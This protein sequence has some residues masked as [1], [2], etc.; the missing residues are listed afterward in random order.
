MKLK[1]G[2]I[3]GGQSPEHEVSIVSARSIASALEKL[4]HHVSLLFIDKRGEWIHID[5]MEE[6]FE[7]EVITQ[8]LIPFLKE[9]D[10]AFPIV[11]GRLGE[12]GALQGFLKMFNIPFVGADVLSSAVCMDKIIS[13]RLLSNAHL[14]VAPYLTLSKVDPFDHDAIEE[15]LGYPCFVKPANTGSS[16]GVSKVKNREALEEAIDLAFEYDTKVIIEAMIDGDEVECSVL[17][18]EVC[19]A[20][21]PARLK[22]THEFYDYDAKYIDPNGAIFEVPVAYDDKLITAIQETAKKAYTA[23]E[24]EGFARVDLFVAPDGKIYVNE[25]NT[26]PGFTPISLYPQMWEATGLSYTKLVQKL[27]DLALDKHEKRKALLVD[28]VVLTKAE[29]K[30]AG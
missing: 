7:G 10:L 4:G 23:L 13:K 27:I 25:I 24:C 16:I 9:L 11:H 2:L 18:N 3:F 8:E 19:E 14:L 26:L 22:A 1:I 28:Y 29:G 21:L 17:G 20:A 6:P 12:D 5:A 30:T 15:A